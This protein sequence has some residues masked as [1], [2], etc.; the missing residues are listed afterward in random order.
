[1]PSFALRRRDDRAEILHLAGDA[2]ATWA[3]ID[4][5]AQDLYGNQLAQEVNPDNPY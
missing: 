5:G 2:L 3:W 1:M 4:I